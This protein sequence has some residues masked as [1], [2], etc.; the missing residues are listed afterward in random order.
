[1]ISAQ[2]ER[3]ATTIPLSVEAL[4]AETLRIAGE[5]SHEHGAAILRRIISNTMLSLI[6]QAVT[7]GS[8]LL[9][10]MAYGRFL[11]DAKFGQL[12]FAISFV[13]L[14]GFPLEFGFNQQLIRDI[15]Q[16]PEQ[17]RRY[18]TSTLI[19]KSTLWLALYALILLLCW[20][21][22]Y[23]AQERALVAICGFTLLWSAVASTFASLHYAVQHAVFPVV[24]TILEKGL[25]AAIGILLL[26]LGA[27]VEVMALVL[28]GGA[29][30]TASWQGFWF[31]R[32]TGIGF[33]FDRSHIREL[34]R[35]ALPFL[36]Y[37]V[38]GVIYYRI[39]T[40]LLSLFTNDAVVGWYGAG[41]RLFDTLCFLP[42]II[43]MAILYPVFSQFS[44]TSD[45]ASEKRLKLALEKTLNF[46]L[47]FALPVATA[48]IVGAASIVG[49]LYHRQE[50]LHTI[51]ALQ[52]LAPGLV[53]L[54][55][56]SAI[57]TI[58]MSTKQEKKI[59]LMA[60]IALVF[61]LGV[62]LFLIPRYQHVG[63]A[64][65]TS[66]TELLL[67]CIG[68]ALIMRRF[69]PLGSL[70]VALKAVCAALVMAVV[71]H[72]LGTVSIFVMLPT[73]ALV[74]LSA[75]AILGTIPRED[76]S[77]LASAIRHKR[78]GVASVPLGRDERDTQPR[79]DDDQSA[80]GAI[81]W[82]RVE[83]VRMKRNFAN[84]VGRSRTAMRYALA[85]VV[86]YT[87]SNIIA[88]VPSF[89]IRHAWYR[90][91]LGWYIGP[92]ASILMGQRVQMAGI[93]TSGK[94]VSIDRGTVINHGCLIYT[95]GGLVIGQH[96]SISAGVWMVTGTHDMN[97]PN[98][99]DEYKPIVIDDYAWIGARA[100]IL[101]GVT[102]GE[103]AVVMAGAVVTRDVE[104][105]TVV[106]GVPA[107]VTGERA[108][109]EPS[110]ELDYRPLFE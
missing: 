33:S 101:A 47:F 50:F 65:A 40:V 35:S 5:Q 69:L 79:F 32:L 71:I 73:A 22:G 85:A 82:V 49:F 58:L 106:G 60:A 13:A 44:A 55:V 98:F 76:I 84:G 8:T 51:P 108:L 1:M 38:L 14:I 48:L 29:L 80:R 16:K 67:M 88:Y 56:N 6:G 34:V 37:G 103:G 54:Y 42:N 46:L 11:G 63:A 41:Y 24:G 97:D 18:F 53:F 52:A 21:L 68:V 87:T 30:L 90:R 10:T 105:Y 72:L 3:S 27:G 102:I 25:G 23:D 70:R 99:R 19:I 66:L 107:K 100:T 39:D 78:R 20:L 91:M 86:K 57:S 43:I 7:W 28:L 61:N 2:E 17:A 15:A 9:L 77:A 93:R 109:R 94:R 31:F 64:M 95:T 81:G 4:A 59:T 92:G 110:Y 62:N 12:Y 75:A 96:V 104:P 83:G 36:A 89:T 74:Y 45:P 26:R